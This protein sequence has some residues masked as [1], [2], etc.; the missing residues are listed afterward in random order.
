MFMKLSKLVVLTG[1]DC[2]M[3]IRLTKRMTDLEKKE[4]VWN[5]LKILEMEV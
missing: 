1:P 3:A 4:P 5:T 2:R